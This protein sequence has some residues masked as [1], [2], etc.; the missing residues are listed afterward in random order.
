MNRMI[1]L[2]AL[3]L[4]GALLF[5]A[6]GG[7]DDDFATSSSTGD[8]DSFD[9]AADDSAEPRALEV[10][11]TSGDAPDNT[12]APA[13]QEESFERSSPL[14]DGGAAASSG[15]ANQPIDIGRDIIFTAQISV[16][17]EDVGTAGAEA[18]QAI[19]EIGGLLFG[20][21]TTTEGVSR[22]VLTFRVR[23]SDFQ[24]AVNRLGGIG[25]LRD[26]TISSD[27]VTE[28]VV[29]LESRII[30]AEASVERL[31]TFLEGAVGLDDVARLEAQL[32]E[33]ETNLELLKGQLRT[34]QDQVSLA[35]ITVTLTQRVPGPDLHVV[36]TAYTGTNGGISCQGDSNISLDEGDAFTVCLEVSNLGDT[37]L[38]DFVITD[39]GFGISTNDIVVDEGDLDGLL[40]PGERILAHFDAEASSFSTGLETSVT[41]KVVNSEGEDLRVSR[42][43]ANGTGFLNVR[44]NNALPGFGDSLEKGL[45]VLAGMIGI[46]VIL[47][48]LFLPFIW[49]PVLLWLALRFLSRRREATYEEELQAQPATPAPEPQ[50]EDAL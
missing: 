44:E 17:V 38:S 3:L 23:P 11:S 10:D 31:R 27:D 45:N 19:N 41:A 48:G 7:S 14:G 22:T 8:S 32:L 6:C 50:P 40:A 36:Q 13:D 49:V 5:A 21:Q 47:A 1:R 26:Q 46:V 16:E 35:T 30:T 39:E 42:V 18:Q 15:G 43:G 12:E 34:V 28:R 25:T 37:S 24:E 29:D 9:S 20:Q 4:T 33:R 2:I